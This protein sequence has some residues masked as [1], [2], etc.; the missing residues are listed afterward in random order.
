MEK[1]WYQSKTVIAGIIIL[2]YGVATAFG[3]DLSAYKEA[4]IAA[5]GGLGIVGIRQALD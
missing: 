1:E 3:V 4:I 5:A 2:A